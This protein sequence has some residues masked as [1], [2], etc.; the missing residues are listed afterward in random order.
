MSKE[1]PNNSF[2]IQVLLDLLKT[3]TKS[4]DTNLEV[5]EK[6]SELLELLQKQKYKKVV[7]DTD[8]IF[9]SHHYN[10]SKIYFAKINNFDKQQIITK[11]SPSATK[12]LTFSISVMS[13]QNKI[14]INTN[15][16]DIL[17]ALG[18]TRKT[19]EK[20]LKE[21]EE[22]K[23]IVSYH[24]DKRSGI[25]TIYMINPLIATASRECHVQALLTDFD[26]VIQS[27]SVKTTSFS[28]IDKI[29]YTIVKAK[30][31][32]ENQTIKYNHIAEIVEE[33]KDE[34]ESE[35][36]NPTN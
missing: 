21:L 32:H 3:S 33:K 7:E 20:G 23:C 11:L 26:R 24:Q 34:F 8:T 9:S 29:R 15:S 25:G 1:N 28:L 18:C 6:T 14:A 35:G 5:I 10:E 16:E 36:N 22:N 2:T 30:Y 13:Q 31:I 19:L 27:K 4:K 12:I 17:K